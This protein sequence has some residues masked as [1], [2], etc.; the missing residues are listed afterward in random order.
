MPLYSISELA[1]RYGVTPKAISDLFFR[2]ALDPS[3][4]MVKAGRKLIP[5]SYLPTVERALRR[6]SQRVETRSV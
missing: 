2:R 1:D 4:C 5:E 3:C 6:T